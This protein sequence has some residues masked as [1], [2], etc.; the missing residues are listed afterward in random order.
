[1]L[2]F[3]KKR[4]GRRYYGLRFPNEAQKGRR[5]RIF[6]RFFTIH[7][8]THQRPSGPKTDTA[9]DGEDVLIFVPEK[10]RDSVEITVS[11]KAFSVMD[12]KPVDSGEYEIQLS[13]IDHTILLSDVTGKIQVSW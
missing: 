6:L 3:E 7:G 8:Q 1:M 9:V 10:Y 12:N 11:D 5:T 13:E 2:K 4:A